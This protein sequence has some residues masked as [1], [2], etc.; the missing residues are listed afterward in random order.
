VQI[1]DCQICGKNLLSA[2][3]LPTHAGD[4]AIIFA[5]LIGKLDSP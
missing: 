5:D 2:A 3:A 4:G 1:F